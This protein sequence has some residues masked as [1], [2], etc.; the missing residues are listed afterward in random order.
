M[1][2]WPLAPELGPQLV[3]PP[4][5]QCGVSWRPP[6]PSHA[7]M[8]HVLPCGWCWG[9]GFQMHPQQLPPVPVPGQ[10]ESPLE[11]LPSQGMVGPKPIVFSR[12][13]SLGCWLE[14]LDSVHLSSIASLPCITAIGTLDKTFL[15]HHEHLSL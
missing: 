1:A 3:V 9:H 13:L 2:R 4:T 12:Q 10:P 7:L 11:A 14:P 5:P 8:L 15:S 6:V